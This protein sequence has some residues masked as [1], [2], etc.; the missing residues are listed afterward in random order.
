ML[1]SNVK[2]L[3][4]W[5]GSDHQHGAGA[6]DDI[7]RGDLLATGLQEIIQGDRCAYRTDAAVN[8]KNGTHGDVYIYVGRAVQGVH[9]DDVLGFV[10]GFVVKSDEVFQFLRGYSAYF[11]HRSQGPN[12]GVVREDVQLHLVFALDV[13]RTGQAQN[14][15]QAGFVDFAVDDLSRQA[16]RR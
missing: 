4:P 2:P 10:V 13:F 1:G 8:A 12:K 5:P 15:R 3:T 6:V 7:A 11:A 16:Y 14:I 9:E